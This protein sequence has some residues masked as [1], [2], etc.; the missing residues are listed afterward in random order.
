MDAPGVDFEGWYAQ[1]YPRLVRAI[2]VASGDPDLAED[3]VAEAFSRAYGSW[4][5]IQSLGN[6]TGWVYRVAVNVLRRRWRRA[7]LERRLLLRARPVVSAEMADAHPEIWR[8]IQALPARQR[9]AVGLR[10]VADLTERQVADAM[11]V[12]EGTASATLAAA[13]RQLAQELEHLEE[14]RWT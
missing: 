11:K 1:E 13:R 2:T 6:P 14:L 8:A 9:E 7:H 10:Y 12:A 3:V 4:G 5:R